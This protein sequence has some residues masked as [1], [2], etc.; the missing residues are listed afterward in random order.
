M[1]I[2]DNEIVNMKKF[3]DHICKFIEENPKGIIP[4]QQD[5]VFGELFNQLYDLKE[6]YPLLFNH[7]PKVLAKLYSFSKISL[8]KANYTVKDDEGALKKF[9]GEFK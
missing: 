6:D 8:N 4:A 9:F 2:I 1:F 7:L 3:S 5:D